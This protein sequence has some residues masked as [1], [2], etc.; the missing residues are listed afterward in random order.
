MTTTTTNTITTDRLGDLPARATTSVTLTAGALV[1]PLSIYTATSDLSVKRSE[2]LSGDPAIEVGRTYIRKDTGEVVQP[3]NVT[4]MAQAVT[5]D[6]AGK[7][8]IVTDDELA[9]IYGDT[10]EASIVTFVPVNDAGRYTLDGIMQVRAKRDKRA[11]AQAAGEAAFS[12]LLTGMRTRNVYALIRL[13][14]RGGPRFALLTWE[15][16]LLT[17]VPAGAVR[18]ALPL[19]TRDHPKQEIDLIGQF[20]DAIGVNS[21]PV[22]DDTPVKVQAF[23]DSKATEAGVA[24][25]DTPAVTTATGV[26][27]FAN[28]DVL[29]V[30]RASIAKA[31]EAKADAPKKPRKTAAKK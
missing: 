24:V 5:G 26:S 17:I 7:W 6:G 20:I 30:L 16:D 31:K 10:G 14:L 11:A 3:E 13:V 8:V 29:D 22:E 18:A 12:L 23:I 19:P 21:I 2:R 25:G 4:R 27:P 9:S 1:I 15:G 28:A